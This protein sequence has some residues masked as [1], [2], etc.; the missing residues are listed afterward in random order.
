M[1]IEVRFYAHLVQYLPSKA[2][3]NRVIVSLKPG[4]SLNELMHQLGLPD[5]IAHSTLVMVNEAHSNQGQILKEGDRVCLLPPIA[6][7]VN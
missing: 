7:G 2:I 1:E 4:S 5:D 6:G 3:E